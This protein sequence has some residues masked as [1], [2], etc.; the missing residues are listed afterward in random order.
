MLKEDRDLSCKYCVISFAR[1]EELLVSVTIKQIALRAGLSVP[2]VS[3]VLNHDAGLFRPE[4]R[5]KVQRAARELGYR[6]NSYRMVLRTKRFNAIGLLCGD[7][8]GC[9][10]GDE[11]FRALVV[12]LHG[13]NQHLVVGLSPDASASLADDETATPKMLREWSVD[14]ILI[15]CS[16]DPPAA[17]LDLIQRNHIPAIWLRCRRA[18]DCV[19]LDE[20]AGVRTAIERLI[21]MGHRKIIFANLAGA[22]CPELYAGYR[23]AMEGAG[24]VPQPLAPAPVAP[25]NQLSFLTHWLRSQ[26]DRGDLPTAAFSVDANGATAFHSAAL[27]LGLSVPGDLSLLASHDGPVEATGIAITAV[28]SPEAELCRQGL[29]ALAEKIADSS[30]DVA[31]RAVPMLFEEG[32]SLAPPN[33]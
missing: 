6:P 25:A 32:A 12:E 28:R 23:A 5:E 3:R 7:A 18:A 9:R 8:P 20:A 13:R 11:G 15:P 4:T 21:R 1:S 10:L 29:G 27:T 2:T 26:R 14:G 24:L 17:L 22:H 30:V 16:T 31:P 33:R 19:Y